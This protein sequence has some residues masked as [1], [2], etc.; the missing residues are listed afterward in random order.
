MT[1]PAIEVRDLHV[2]RSGR[3]ILRLDRLC[4]S[5]GE[6]VAILGPNGAGKTTLLK[7]LLGFMRPTGGSIRVFGRQV[8]VPLFQRLTEN[9]CWRLCK[10]RWTM[11]YLPQV[12]AAGCE[13]PLT[14]REVVS[15]GRT[16]KAGLFHALKKTDW[17]LVDDWLGRL[18]LAG[19]AER[20][21]TTLSGGE[22]R[23]ALIAKAM[24]QQPDVFLLD[25]PT[26]NLDLFWREQI[27]ET[28]EHLHRPGRLTIVLVCH[29]LE[30]VPAC[31]GRLVILNE[32][33]LLADGPPQEVLDS[34][35]LKML[36]G[37]RL[38]LYQSGG[39]YAV[40]P[41]REEPA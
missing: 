27:V 33:R 37:A 15:I 35:R 9:D 11:A 12:L 7:C 41:D 28:L 21:Y 16:G 22:Q 17:L 14:L 30:A 36:Y 23:K 39:R 24:V 26:A 10:L 2:R 20:A 18:G 5:R 25:E 4:I 31:V 13:T 29:E 32:G 6:A 40:V 19:L 3:D 34:P 1:T 8:V 38:K